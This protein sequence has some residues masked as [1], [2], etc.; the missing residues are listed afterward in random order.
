MA[1][2]SLSAEKLFF[3][4]AFTRGPVSVLKGRPARFQGTGGRL[5]ASRS[6]PSARSTREQHCLV[7]DS[8]LRPRPTRRGAPPSSSHE[9]RLPPREGARV[10][11]PAASPHLTVAA[12]GS[13]GVE[14]VEPG[15]DS[16]VGSQP[17]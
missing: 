7:L 10:A 9:S 15:R 12:R 1:A 17:S 14:R 11:P 8:L 2:R 16:P 13:G 4:N 3:G 6:A 5:P